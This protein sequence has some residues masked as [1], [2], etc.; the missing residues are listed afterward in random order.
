LLWQLEALVQWRPVLMIFEDVHWI[1]PTSHELLD[2]IIERV[3]RLPGLL[4][5]TFRPEF[6]PPWTG[7]PHVTTVTLNRLDRGDGATLVKQIAGSKSALPGDIVDEIVERTDGVPLFVEELTKA[8]LEADAHDNDTV[9]ALAALPLPAL[10]I[11]A[12]LHALLMA[13]LDRLGS[14]AK[15]IAQIGAAVGREFSHELLAAIAPRNAMQLQNA[16]DPLVGAGLLFQ[17][18]APP[19][20]AYA[21]KHALVQDAAYGTLLRGT[22]KELHARIAAVLETQFPDIIETQPELLARHTTEAGLVRPAI[23]YW[24][25]AGTRARRR[26]ADVEAARHFRRALA[27]AESLPDTREPDG[28]ELDLCIDLGGALVATSGYGVDECRDLFARARALCDRLGDATPKLFP[29]LYGHWVY[30]HVNG[31]LTISVDLAEQFLDQAEC[32]ADRALEMIG[33]R[34]VGFTLLARGRADLALPHLRCALAAYDPTRDTPLG[35]VYGQ[36]PKVGALM[37]A[38]VALSHLGFPDE[39]A[40]T[41]RQG[42]DEARML[43]HLNTLAWALFHA[44]LFH[45]L[46]RDL[47]A[48]EGLAGELIAIAREQDALFWATRGGAILSC[49]RAWRNASTNNLAQLRQ[50][51]EAMHAETS[52]RVFTPCIDVVAAEILCTSGDVHGGLRLLEEMH[53]LVEQWEQRLAEAEGYRVRADL[54]L[55]AAAVGEAEADLFRAIDVARGQSAKTFELR[56]ATSLARLW[57]HNKRHEAHALLAPVYA[58]FTEGFDTPDLRSAKALLDKLVD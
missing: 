51:I 7:Q 35:Y 50:D 55:S 10:A 8:V 38:G 21:F 6:P 14:A 29:V 56:A 12:T 9:G 27:L 44:S 17:R 25:Q 39:A 24:R 45:V 37:G 28:L 22:R 36:N 18:G 16:L 20:A 1:D 58:W 31:R 40:R 11:P 57:R 26:S 5:V 47:V 2:L 43:A 13:R 30:E 48:A 42:M 19:Q 3:R 41:V 46:R 15:E 53:P 52:W 32:A 49:A 23:G 34:L 4:L 54:L 33:H